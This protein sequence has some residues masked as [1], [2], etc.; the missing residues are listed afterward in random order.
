LRAVFIDGATLASQWGP[1]AVVA[2]WTLGLFVL[3]TRRF[4]WV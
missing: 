2:A 3:A 4:K 1:I